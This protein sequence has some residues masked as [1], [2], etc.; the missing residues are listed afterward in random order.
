MKTITTLLVL[1]SFVITVHSE[2]LS[3]SDLVK[4]NELRKAV[5]DAYTAMRPTKGD[6]GNLD[7]AYAQL[8]ET[9][10]PKIF[11]LAQKEP[12]S[13]PAFDVFLW[14]AMDSYA[15]RGLIRTYQLQSLEYLANY[16]STNSK[17]GPLCSYLGR[18]CFNTWGGNRMNWIWLKPGVEHIS[19]PAYGARAI[20]EMG[21]LE[22]NK[23]GRPA[24]DFLKSVIKNNSNRAI[25]AQAIYALGR[26]DA[27]KFA[28]LDGF[29]KIPVYAKGM[30]AN[31][32]A[33]WKTFGS[34]QQAAADAEN[35]FNDVIANYSDCLDLGERSS[36]KEKAPRLKELAEQNL[37]ALKHLSL[38]KE[39]PEIEAKGVDGKLFKLSD[40]RGKICV[41]TFWA[42]WC[43]P[44]MAMVPEERALVQQMQGKPFSLIGV[45]GDESLS[46]AKR[47]MEREQMT[48]PSFW[49]GKE[50]S[51]GP[52]AK[53]WNVKGWPTI[54]ILDAKGVIRFNGAAADDLNRCVDELMKELADTSL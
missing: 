19:N 20:K 24:V 47:A 38:G 44:C 26:F 34:S 37:F 4:I 54:Y 17:L 30:S 33:E 23:S 42:S 1:M 49:N 40:S 45:N 35:E 46:N 27:E 7:K 11:S 53:A 5:E 41:L 51:K 16:H 39:A 8:E 36:P 10:V 15:L 32:L 12:E 13:Q 14:I 48:W 22:A 29:E 3:P 31:V 18:Y 28:D 52:I 2:Q 9:N 50:G 21:R 25:R 43:G 6:S